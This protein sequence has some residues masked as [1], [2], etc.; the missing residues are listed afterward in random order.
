MNRRHFLKALAGIAMLPILNGLRSL[1]PARSYADA[2]RA[3]KPSYHASLVDAFES[4]EGTF[5][6]WYPAADAAILPWQGS[7]GRV[8]MWNRALTSAELAAWHNWL[9]VAACP[10]LEA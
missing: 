1:V 10:S 6:A 5:M 3:T 8:F 4:D 9:T 7:M 2:V